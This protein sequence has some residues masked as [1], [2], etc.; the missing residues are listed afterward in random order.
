MESE[1]SF[2][3]VLEQELKTTLLKLYPLAA[4]PNFSHSPK[5]HSPRFIWRHH[6]RNKKQNKKP[7]PRAF[8]N[9]LACVCFVFQSGN[10]NKK[11]YFGVFPRFS[12]FKPPFCHVASSL[13]T[14]L[15]ANAPKPSPSYPHVA[16]AKSAKRS[17]S[18][19]TPLIQRLEDGIN[20]RATDCD[21][22]TQ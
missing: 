1:Q 15:A 11:A 5:L 3:C 22:A 12:R 9:D 17:A 10:N 14:P 7:K 6:V 4:I 20:I 2:V 19:T 13:Q 21:T 18:G 16:T 8:M